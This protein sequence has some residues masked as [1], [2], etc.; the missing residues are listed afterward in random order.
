[1]LP[2]I[3]IFIILLLIKN[4][5][6][7]N[8]YSFIIIFLFMGSRYGVGSDWELY[9]PI[10]KKI[11][12]LDY[13]IFYPFFNKISPM[14][15]GWG[16]LYR[17]FNFEISNRILYKIVWFFKWPQ[18]IIYLYSFLCLIFIK[19]GLENIKNKEYIKYSWILFFSFQEFFLLYLNL[20]RQAVA[21]SI[22]F[23]SYKFIIKRNKYK[24]IACIL[25]AMSFHTSAIFCVF[26]YLVNYLNS[27]S[28][29]TIILLY[30]LSFFV[31]DII[32][33]I[34]KSS[35]FIP[36]KYIGYLQQT[37]SGGIKINYLLNFLGIFFIIF[38]VNKKETRKLI[39]IILIGF[40]LN[41][42]F[43]GTGYLVIRTRIY[44]LIFILYLV[45]LLCKNKLKKYIFI[46]CCYILLNLSLINDIVSEYGRIYVPYKIFLK[47][48]NKEEWE[49]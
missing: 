40:Y 38:I 32:L 46:V 49:M 21:I 25:I 6:N 13:S 30:F 29:K 7:S 35:T 12:F 17:Y 48:N 3:V 20:M 22:V 34:L 4:N 36:T 14:Q 1:M 27:I 24:F 41:M 2:Y 16:E 11:E 8:F 9:Y 33:F 28:K 5:K 26:L 45:P 19:L 10:A 15:Y 44:F 18:L 37:F 39:F 42:I 31:K 23:F 47:I 43:K